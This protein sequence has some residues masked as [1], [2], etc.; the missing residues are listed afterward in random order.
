M[1]VKEMA[2]GIMTG[3]KRTAAK[4]FQTFFTYHSGIFKCSAHV[5]TQVIA[6]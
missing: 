3:S 4:Y 6:K 2:E 5:G 1:S